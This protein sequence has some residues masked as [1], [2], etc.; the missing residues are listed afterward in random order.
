MP[1]TRPPRQQRLLPEAKT[2]ERHQ[3][4]KCG[5]HGQQYPCR[6][7]VQCPKFSPT[8]KRAVKHNTSK[9]RKP[10]DSKD[11]WVVQHGACFT[12]Q[13]S[14]QLGDDHSTEDQ[15]AGS[16]SKPRP[17]VPQSAEGRSQ[18]RP[19]APIPRGGTNH[20][21]WP[22][23]RRR[24]THSCHPHAHA[25]RLCDAPNRKG[26]NQSRHAEVQRHH[27]AQRKGVVAQWSAD[28]SEQGGVAHT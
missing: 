28:R 16:N 10:A 18:K 11:A 4:G 2:T 8:S 1:P 24:V 22:S 25:M 14:W 23:A 15:P 26:R 17:T 19:N 27:A 13:T 21:P 12:E 6:S 7:Q 20:R 9:R 5:H 3:T